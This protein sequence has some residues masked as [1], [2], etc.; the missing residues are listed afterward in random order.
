MK[1]KSFRQI[2]LMVKEDDSLAAPVK[3]GLLVNLKILADM[4][5]SRRKMLREW[6]SNN[7][8][9]CSHCEGTGF[10]PEGKR[11]DEKE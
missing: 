11:R 6:D 5:R 10:V 4:E 8:V 9:M 2:Y 1:S 3:E 7:R